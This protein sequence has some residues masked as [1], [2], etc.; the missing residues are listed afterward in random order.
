MRQTNIVYYIFIY[1]LVYTYSYLAIYIFKS[2]AV[3]IEPRC[4]YGRPAAFASR[5]TKDTHHRVS[6][7]E[8]VHVGGPKQIRWMTTE[9][10]SSFLNLWPA[11][12]ICVRQRTSTRVK[13]SIIVAAFI[14]YFYLYNRRARW[15]KIMLFFG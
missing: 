11:A 9:L 1:V 7:P 3:D 12:G 5:E 13:C 2:N 10:Y 8:A 14:R 15:K 4:H 6:R